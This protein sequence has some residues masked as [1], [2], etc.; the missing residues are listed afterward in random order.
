MARGSVEKDAGCGRAADGLSRG[1]G[2]DHYTRRAGMRGK[3]L[4]A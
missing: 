3:S 4:G 2:Q 1:A